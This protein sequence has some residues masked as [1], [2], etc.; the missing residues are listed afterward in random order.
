MCRLA[1][2]RDP[3]LS[4]LSMYRFRAMPDHHRLK[5]TTATWAMSLRPG[6]IEVCSGR[7]RRRKWSDEAKTVIIAE[8]LVTGAVV[9]LVAV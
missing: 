2:E 6:Q 4:S 5:L 9:S 7:K 3:P 8:A 1:V